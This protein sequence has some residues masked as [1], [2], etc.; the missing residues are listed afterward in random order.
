MV[1]VLDVLSDASD[2][3]ICQIGTPG[4]LVSVIRFPDG[5]MASRVFKRFALDPVSEVFLTA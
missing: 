2:P 1:K 5:N 4:V 3:E